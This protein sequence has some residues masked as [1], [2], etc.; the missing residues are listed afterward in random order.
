MPTIN[1]NAPGMQRSAPSPA[2]GLN[3]MV[4]EI[5]TFVTRIRSAEERINNIRKSIQLNGQN[6]LDMN[7]K[8]NEETTVINSEITDLKRT[9]NDIKS[10]IELIIKELTLT[11]KREDLEVVNK[12]LELWKPVN[13]V[14]QREVKKIIKAYMEDMGL[15][16]DETKIQ[17]EEDKRLPRSNY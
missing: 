13:F 7:K 1:T 6:Y 10:K 16:V 4:N 17:S 5:R 9:I 12:Y 8:F 14:T 3:P 2:G 11:S 15:V